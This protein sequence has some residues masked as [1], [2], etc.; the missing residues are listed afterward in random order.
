MQGLEAVIAATRLPAGRW[1][2]ISAAGTKA[3]SAVEAWTAGRLTG[4]DQQ[5]AD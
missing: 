5:V 3:A 2:A 4:Q 1:M